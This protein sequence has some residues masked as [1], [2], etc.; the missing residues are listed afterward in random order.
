MGTRTYVFLSA[1]SLLRNTDEV[2]ARL[3]RAERECLDVARYWRSVG[4]DGDAVTEWAMWEDL[5][6]HVNY[7]GP[8]S[9]GLVVTEHAAR[10]YA[11]A[12]WRGF[13][14][15]PPL[16]SVH[17]TAFRSI[18]TALGSAGMA[19]THD[20][21]NSV[22]ESFDGGAGLD[23]CIVVLRDTLGPP[24]PDVRNVDPTVVAE[25]RRCVPDVWFWEPL[26]K[27]S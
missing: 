15:I 16:R 1:D 4:S 18:A 3:K 23:G 27:T 10:I 26:P 13:L 21:L 14:S 17:L 24:Q 11:G 7:R 6:D 12:R 8:G 19:I 22:G 5:G 20:S 2:L 9:L 25:T